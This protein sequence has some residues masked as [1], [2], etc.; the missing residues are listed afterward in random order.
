MKFDHMRRIDPVTGN[1]I[2]DLFNCE[3]KKAHVWTSIEDLS[4]PYATK[5]VSEIET[6]IVDDKTGEVYAVHV[7]NAFQAGLAVPSVI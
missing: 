2:E 7:D 5:T 4:Y 3:L 6:L 1:A